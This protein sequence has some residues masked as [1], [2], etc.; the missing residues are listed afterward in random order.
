MAQALHTFGGYGLTTDYDIHLYNLRA[1]ALPLILGDP[2]A[3]LDEAGRR[4]YGAR[5]LCCR[6]QVKSRSSSISATK[7]ARSLPKSMLSLRPTSPELRAKAHYS[8]DG[9]VPEFHKKIAEARLAMPTGPKIRR[10]QCLRLCDQCGIQR[11][12][13]ARLDDSRGR[14]DAMVGT[15]I[16]KFGGED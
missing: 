5:P 12:G 13:E 1:K 14:R 9:H 3:L 7:P 16:R 8:F 2:E 6:R 4:L 15:I 10:P 11:L